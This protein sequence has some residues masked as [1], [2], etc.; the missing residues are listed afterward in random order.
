MNL[1]L[2]R[3]A[4]RSSVLEFG[5][6]ESSLNVTGLAQ[7]SDLIQHVQPQG[8]LPSPSTL[9]SSPKLRAR[10]TLEPLS[11]A[12]PL[13]IHILSDLDERRENE[14]LSKFERRVR[15]VI[16]FTLTLPDPETVYLCTHL[17]VLE[18]AAL[19]WPTNF[20]ER[21][22][23]TPWSTLEYQVFKRVDGIL[24]SGLRGRVEPRR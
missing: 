18:A 20:T 13:K 22:S 1:V 10:Q 15:D 3:H 6:T 21:E 14:S 19:L 16:D 4:T 8:E 17:D 5:S 12:L 7:A 2:L 24:Q 23:A 11:Q 9:F